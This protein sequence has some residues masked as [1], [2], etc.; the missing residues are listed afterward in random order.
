MDH[1][2][3]SDQ[4]T[5]DSVDRGAAY[6]RL[7]PGAHDQAAIFALAERSSRAALAGAAAPLRTGIEPAPSAS[8]FA[9]FRQASGNL[10][11]AAAVELEIV[12]DFVDALGRDGRISAVVNVLVVDEEGA[13]VARA[14]FDWVVLRRE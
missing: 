10:E 9:Y 11:A 1:Y 14:S 6:A 5:V 7:T 12:D 13:P 8:S 4:I 2:N 3:V